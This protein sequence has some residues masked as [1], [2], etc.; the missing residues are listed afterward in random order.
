MYSPVIDSIKGHDPN[1]KSSFTD[2]LI[3]TV[4]HKN[5]Q[6]IKLTYV[7]FRVHVKIAS[8]INNVS[9]T[10]FNERQPILINFWQKYSEEYTIKWLTTEP[11]T[12]QIITSLLAG[13]VSNSNDCMLALSQK[14]PD[15]RDDYF[16]HTSISSTVRPLTSY[17][18]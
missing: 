3:Y 13:Y 5:V 2:C 18:H 1:I 16:H 4:S 12:L 14:Y 10:N 7:G 11:K 6:Q 17:T 15:N 8:R 9:C